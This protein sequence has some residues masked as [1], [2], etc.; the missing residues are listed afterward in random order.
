MQNTTTVI[1]CGG[2]GK[3]MGGADK[4][5]LERAG[6]PLLEHI[7]EELRLLENLVGREPPFMAG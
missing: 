4:P 6:R 2:A 1:L 3:R 5:L 7:L